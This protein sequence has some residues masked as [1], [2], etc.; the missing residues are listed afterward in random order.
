M[1]CASLVRT[2]NCLMM[3]AISVWCWPE[4]VLDGT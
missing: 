3:M 4:L 2:G 1:M